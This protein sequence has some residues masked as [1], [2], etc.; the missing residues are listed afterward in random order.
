[1]SF[2]L[3]EER[4]ACLQLAVFALVVAELVWRSISTTATSTEAE[5][6][7]ELYNYFKALDNTDQDPLFLLLFII[8]GEMWP[9]WGVW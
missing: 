2:V 6:V 5:Q 3:A 1:M 8:S 4:A 7:S 9:S